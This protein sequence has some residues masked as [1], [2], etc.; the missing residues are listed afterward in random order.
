MFISSGTAVISHPLHQNDIMVDSTNDQRELMQQPGAASAASKGAQT[1]AGDGLNTPANPAGVN[2]AASAT[3][4]P[5]ASSVMNT[6][7]GGRDG[8]HGSGGEGGSDGAG[9]GPAP[10]GPSE[11]ED[12]LAG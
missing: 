4:L 2:L 12:D 5:S 9:G 3:N 7:D 10:G 1:D 8:V 11:E 6:G